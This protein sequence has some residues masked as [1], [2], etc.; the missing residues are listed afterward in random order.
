[1][2]RV[3]IVEDEAVLRSAMARGIS[4]LP[5]VVAVEAGTLQAALESIDANAPQMIIS[6]IDLPDRSGLELLGELGRRGLR[7]P[8]LFV[9]AYLKAYSAQIP[10][11]ADVD[12][13]EKPVELEE[14]RA[15]VEQR[16][17]AATSAEEAPFGP[18]D[19]LQL[20]CLGHRSVVLD[21]EA[22]DTKGS[23][24]VHAGT[25][26]TAE[27]GSVEGEAAF[28]RLAFLPGATVRA[29][30]LRD[31]P[32]PR[33]IFEGWEALLMD[34]AR[35]QDENAH[36]ARRAIADDDPFGFDL[37]DDPPPLPPPPRA[38]A[39]TLPSPAVEPI[40]AGA[41]SGARRSVRP[42]EVEPSQSDFDVA[43]EAG[44]EALLGKDYPAAYA[45]FERAK[46]INPD[47]PKVLTNLERLKQ[48]GFGRS[49]VPEA[50]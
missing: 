18:A 9:S 10:P 27:D 47:D 43:F 23:I 1:M 8:L 16:L 36:K 7:V 37:A 14:L 35:E 32:G 48:L 26:W 46:A 39:P 30:V 50:S 19:Y 29:R 28:R 31:A 12:V 49:S 2:P 11:H 24:V 21:I 33:A 34:A 44:V 15:L 40:S 25:L 3:L 42:I 4:K 5:G 20:A 22:P 17:S 6:D 13:R 41:Q 45:A 38:P